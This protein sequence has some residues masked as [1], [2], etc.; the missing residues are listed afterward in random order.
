MNSND[1][2]VW[3]NWFIVVITMFFGLLGGVVAMYYSEEK[4]E[5]K[6]P[7]VIGPL[8]ALLIFTVFR[9]SEINFFSLIAFSV[10]F[11]YC[12]KAAFDAGKKAILAKKIK[13]QLSITEEQL[14]NASNIA[15]RTM[16]FFK[17]NANNLSQI[18][19]LTG[20]T[21]DE[22]LNTTLRDL[23]KLQAELSQLNKQIEATQTEFK[24]S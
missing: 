14:N 19:F 5:N 20:S 4:S 1:F 9:P 23:D 15:G 6:I 13:L 2:L 18:K 3:Q 24:N 10:L 7:L 21:S 12:G 11:G 16:G 22:E 8:A 17:P